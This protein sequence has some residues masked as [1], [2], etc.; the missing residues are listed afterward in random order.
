MDQTG[1]VLDVLVQR[2]R[3][4]QAAKRLLRKLL[5]RQMRR[6]RQLV[7]A[8]WPDAVDRQWVSGLLP[9]HA[10][11]F[12]PDTECLGPGGSV[13]GGGGVIAAEV[14]EIINLIVG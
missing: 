1:V 13:L 3:D 4:K 2:R 5:K 12:G 10:A 7:T 6:H 9:T 11:D 8:G 14:E